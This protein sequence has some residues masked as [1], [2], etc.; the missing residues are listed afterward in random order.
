MERSLLSHVFVTPLT[1]NACLQ[2]VYFTKL[3]SKQPIWMK[4]K[5]NILE[6]QQHGISGK[7]VRAV[8]EKWKERHHGKFLSTLQNLLKKFLLHYFINKL[9]TEAYNACQLTAT[10]ADCNKW[11]CKW[12]SL[13]ISSVFISMNFPVPIGKQTMSHCILMIWFRNQ[14]I[15]MVLL[16]DKT[17][18]SRQW[19]CLQGI[20]ELFSNKPWQRCC[21]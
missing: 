3:N 10:A 14:S 4:S 11:W 8:R 12:I 1:K 17:I 6:Q 19:W 9:Q 20:L 2:T 16:S 13:K 15:S 5:R 18:M 21:R 7:K